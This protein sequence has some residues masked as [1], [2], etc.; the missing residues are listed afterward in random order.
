MNLQATMHTLQS[1]LHIERTAVLDE[2]REAKESL[3]LGWHGV[4]ERGGKDVHTLNVREAKLV[5]V[6]SVYHSHERKVDEGRRKR[7]LAPPDESVE[8]TDEHV[9]PY[10]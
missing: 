8:Q 10:A 3:H 5:G 1:W 2:R 6:Q 9:L 7:T 4:E